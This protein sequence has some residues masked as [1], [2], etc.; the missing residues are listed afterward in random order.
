MIPIMVVLLWTAFCETLAE[1]EKQ[2]L[3]K[4]LI[5]LNANMMLSYVFQTVCG[6][7]LFAETNMKMLSIVTLVA[8]KCQT[9]IS[10]I[11]QYNPILMQMILCFSVQNARKKQEIVMSLLIMRFIEI[12]QNNL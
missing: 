2:E 12:A 4:L 8:K 1:G 10:S 5:A 3:L 11:S 7:A 9:Q 6:S